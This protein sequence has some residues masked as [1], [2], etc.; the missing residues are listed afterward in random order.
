MAKAFGGHGLSNDNRQGVRK[1]QQGRSA[2][3]RKGLKAG[4]KDGG[5]KADFENQAKL[6]Q[7]GA[8]LKDWN[9][10]QDSARQDWHQSRLPEHLDATMERMQK[11]LDP[12]VARESA[13][14]QFG[15]AKV[16]LSGSLRKPAKE[17]KSEENPHGQGQQM[18]QFAGP[19]QTF[20]GVY[21]DPED[22]EGKEYPLA[23]IPTLTSENSTTDDN[24]RI[25]TIGNTRYNFG[26]RQFE[27]NVDNRDAYQNQQDI[28][29]K[30][31]D[32]FHNRGQQ[33]SLF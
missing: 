3:Y 24:G 26:R 22:E 30:Q 21:K 12:D 5:R 2:L 10:T 18:K 6:M 33:M 28:Q 20:L 32:D 31:A 19:R 9:S 4:K 11:H 17:G 29:D 23:N 1:I 7:Y 14:Y 8:T 27:S 13:S 25:S 15:N 16:S